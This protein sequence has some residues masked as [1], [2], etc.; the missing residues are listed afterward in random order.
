MP[1]LFSR[2]LPWDVILEPLAG[3]E[4][5]VARMAPEVASLLGHRYGWLGGP[6]L[7]L[8][9]LAERNRTTVAR[10]TARMVLAERAAREVRRREG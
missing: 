4:R 6:P 3:C 5:L 7:T 2:L 9:E 10:M 8:E 1:G